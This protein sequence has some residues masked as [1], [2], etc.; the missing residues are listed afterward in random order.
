[1]VWAG[2]AA[3]VAVGDRAVAGAVR[4][5]GLPALGGEPRGDEADLDD[6]VGDGVRPAHIGGEVVG[7]DQGVSDLLEGDE[8]L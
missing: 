7:F 6:E 2:L 5:G 3:P 1:M 4:L 8:E